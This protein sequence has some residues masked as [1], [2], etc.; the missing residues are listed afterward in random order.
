MTRPEILSF[1]KNSLTEVAGY[2]L[3]F[4][5]RENELMIF[6]AFDWSSSHNDMGFFKYLE[7]FSFEF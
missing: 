1:G 4:L 2:S 3:K 6:F 7:V 5:L